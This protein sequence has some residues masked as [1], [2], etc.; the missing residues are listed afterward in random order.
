MK[1]CPAMKGRYITGTRSMLNCKWYDKKNDLCVWE[2]LRG[3]PNPCESN[4][5]G[6]EEAKVNVKEDNNANNN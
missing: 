5:D 1:E 2:Y 4:F 6:L 3:R